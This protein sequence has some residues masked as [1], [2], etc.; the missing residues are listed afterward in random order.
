MGAGGHWEAAPPVSGFGV[1]SVSNTH[2]HTHAH[3]D[4]FTLEAVELNHGGGLVPDT[5]EN[6]NINHKFTRIVSARIQS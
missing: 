5:R 6:K 1:R 4:L 2:T 3:T